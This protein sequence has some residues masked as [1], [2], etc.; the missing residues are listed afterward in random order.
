M[1]LRETEALS[2]IH[3]YFIVLFYWKYIHA[4]NLL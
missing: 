3:I 1:S 4:T 2:Y